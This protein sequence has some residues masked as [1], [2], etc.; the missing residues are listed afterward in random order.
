[1]PEFYATI[2]WN[3]PL[4]MSR[5]EVIEAKDQAEAFQKAVSL[6]NANGTDY[7]IRVD[8]INSP[9]DNIKTG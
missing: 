9:R 3:P 1:M 7:C 6:A 8:P 2:N 4:I 5:G